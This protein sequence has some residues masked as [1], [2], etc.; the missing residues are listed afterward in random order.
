MNDTDIEA[1]GSFPSLFQDA[2]LFT[3]DPVNP[4]YLQVCPPE[5]VASLTPDQ[6]EERLTKLIAQAHKIVDKA[7]ELA[8]GRMRAAWCILYSGGNDSTVLAHLM[9]DRAD[10]AIHCNTTIG[11][12]ATRQFVRDTCKSWGL[13]L[14]ER[15]APISYRELVLE[16]GFPGPGRHF[17]MYSRLKERALDAVRREL[18]TN[19]RRERVLYIAG[20]RRSE[21]ERRKNIPLYE[22]DGS[23]IWASPIAMWTKHDLVMYRAIKSRDGDPVPFNPVTDAL[24]MSGECLCGAFAKPDELERIE[25]WYPETAAEIRQLEAEVEAAG[26]KPPFC[27]WGHGK[28]KPTEKTGAMCTSCDLRQLELWTDQ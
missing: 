24:G 2:E 13:E 27:K 28:G 6:R 8:D 14:I 1:D 19:P 17:M 15:V 23:A 21:S 9:R 18:V 16:R 10:Y 22:T 11:I 12:E 20:R 5:I 3:G 7:W 26:H 25:A 4:D